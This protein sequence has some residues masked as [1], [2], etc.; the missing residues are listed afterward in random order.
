MDKILPY[1][2]S[3]Q[4]DEFSTRNVP[5]QSELTDV[6]FQK[7]LKYQCSICGKICPSKKTLAMHNNVHT[8]E[9]PFVT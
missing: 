1:F 6:D 4:E 2:I 8:G 7:F 3:G 9:K 5:N